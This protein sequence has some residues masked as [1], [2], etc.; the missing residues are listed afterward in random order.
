MPTI[1]KKKSL[2]SWFHKI[3]QLILFIKDFI[4]SSFAYKNHKERI[5]DD[6]VTLKENYLFILF[7]LMHSVQMQ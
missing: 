2:A 7:T 6:A 5:T 3:T 4:K 1:L